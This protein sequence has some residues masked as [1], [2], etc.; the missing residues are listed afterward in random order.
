MKQIVELKINRFVYRQEI[1]PHRTL[2]DVLRN[3]LGLTGTKE[4]CDG[5][6]CGACT[7]LIDGGPVLSCLTLAVDVQGKQ[8][9][10]IEGL[11]QDG[12]IDPV[13]KAFIEEGAFQCGFCTPGMILSAKALF[14]HTPSPSVEEIKESLSGNLCRCTGYI[15]PIHALV[16]LAK[17]KGTGVPV[18]NDC[19]RQR[20]KGGK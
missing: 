6:E 10:T 4:G 15:K 7:V 19:K 11:A 9:T 18:E 17:G 3:D 16:N 8:I 2:L 5:G 12:E 20:K 1:E 13:Q 14:N